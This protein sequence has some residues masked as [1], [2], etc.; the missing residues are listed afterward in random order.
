M[1][2]RYQ[3]HIFSFVF[4]HQKTDKNTFEIL[5]LNYNNIRSKQRK[6]FNILFYFSHIQ[7]DIC[8]IVLYSFVL[9]IIQPFVFFPVVI[10]STYN[11]WINFCCFFFFIETLRFMCV[12]DLL[13]IHKSL[14]E[15]ENTKFKRLHYA[16]HIEINFTISI[17]FRLNEAI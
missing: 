7:K 3:E 5:K 4:F 8:Q 10:I 14:I 13:S 2:G 17:H 15:S 11:K 12:I 6:Q 1:L 9:T 16:I